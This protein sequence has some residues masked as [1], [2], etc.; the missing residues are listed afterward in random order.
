MGKHRPFENTIIRSE[1]S[2][3]FLLPPR[4]HRK[5]QCVNIGAFWAVGKQWENK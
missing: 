4:Y 1:V 5:S 3:L 2:P